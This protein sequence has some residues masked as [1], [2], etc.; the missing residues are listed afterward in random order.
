[1]AALPFALSAL[2]SGLLAV[3]RRAFLQAMASRPLVAGGIIGLCFA[4]PVEGLALGAVLELFFLG[5]VNMGAA[6]PDNELFTVVAATSC[7]CALLTHAKTPTPSALAL[8]ALVAL[9][10]AKLGRWADQV[11]DQV[12]ASAAARAQREGPMPRRLR[13]NLH[14]LWMPFVSAAAMALCGGLVG[15]WLLPPALAS[16]PMGLSRALSFAWGAL[17]M[18]AAAS[19][20]HSIRTA[21]GGLYAGLSAAVAAGIQVWRMFAS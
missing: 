2:A 20:L 6:L 14:G 21:R 12:S 10:A 11:S 19:A 9:P 7:A 16:S 4:R 8:A 13:S 15:R 3:E 18:S 1:M 5:G 17:L